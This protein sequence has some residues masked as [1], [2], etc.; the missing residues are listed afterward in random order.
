MPTLSRFSMTLRTKLVFCTAVILIIACLLLGWLFAQQQVRST[1]ESSV[2]SGTLL[3]QHLAHMGRSSIRGGDIPRLNQLIQEILAVNPVAYVAVISS[4]GELQAGFG[5]GAWKDQFSPHETSRREFT[6]TKLLQ[7]RLLDGLTS[8]PLVSAIDLNTE[9]PVLRPNLELTPSELL[10]LVGGAELPIFYDIT[11]HVPPYPLVPSWDPALQLTF[12]ERLD[13]PQASMPHHPM[14]PTLVQI[15]LATSRLQHGLRRLLWQ[16]IIITLSTLAGGLCIAVFLARRITVPLRNLT[17]A[18]TKLA[19][20]E[21][22]P[23]LAIGT[24][25]EIGT[26]TGVFNNMAMRLHS[27]ERELRELAHSLEDRVKARTAEL[28]AANTRLQEMDR[29][30]SI[31]V[32]TASHELRTPLTSM[33]V[34]VANLRDGIDGAI[35]DDQRGSL[36]RVEANLSRLQLLI[37]DLLDLSQIEMGQT[38]LHVEPVAVGTVIAKAVDDVSPLAFERR[39]RVIITLASDLPEVSADPDKLH[40]ITLNLLHNAVKFTRPDTTVNVSAA[41]VPDGLVQISV[42]DAGPGI[43]LEDA[44]KVFQPFYRAATTQK[45]S[46]GAGLGLAIAKLLV[47]LHD[48]RLWVETVPGYGSR[49]S[50]TLHSIHTRRPAPAQALSLLASSPHTIG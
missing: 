32:S 41:P 16:A 38:T 47:E 15:G 3:A 19:G 42:S 12:E 33:K 4:H 24:R 31:F 40:Q 14:T 27:R 48:G 49:F 46:K 30:K 25:D 18:A 43:T 37:E 23:V 34:H 36:A 6:T 50:F 8:E 35:T 9:G 10:S 17:I 11:I 1:A 21:T 44:D 22:V 5:K 13:E 7:P 26:L 45:K 39:V 29:R 2:Q 28:A 20:G